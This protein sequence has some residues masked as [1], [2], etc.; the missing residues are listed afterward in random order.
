MIGSAL[1]WVLSMYCF[2]HTGRYLPGVPPPTNGIFTIEQ[3]P[4][5]FAENPLAFNVRVAGVRMLEYVWR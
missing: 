4:M 2:W 1:I 5:L 3:V